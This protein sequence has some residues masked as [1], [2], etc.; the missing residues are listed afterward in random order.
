MFS[1][2]RLPVASIYESYPSYG[3][4]RVPCRRF[5]GGERRDWTTEERVAGIKL[6]QWRGERKNSD[7]QRRGNSRVASQKTDRSLMRPTFYVRRGPPVAGKFLNLPDARDN[8]PGK[9]HDAICR[10]RN[11]NG[12]LDFYLFHLAAL[13]LLDT[14]RP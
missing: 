4:G 3:G 8:G 12:K 11:A 14:F 10:R 1:Y 13:C 6:V 7:F 9:N 5:V 2:F